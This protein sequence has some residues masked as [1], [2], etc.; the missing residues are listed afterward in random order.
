MQRKLLGIAGIITYTILLCLSILFY[1]ER[2]AFT[3]GAFHLFCLLKD[4]D[5]AIQNYR[6]IALFTQSFPLVGAYLGGSLAQVSIAYSVSFV[7]LNII[8]FSLLFFGFK[9]N[10]L[11][12]AY[13][14]FC[15]I[16]SRHS[17]Y[18][19]LSEIGQGTAACFV[20]IAYI[21]HSLENKKQI[22]LQYSIAALLLVSCAFAH[23]LMVFLWLFLMLFL[24][25]EQWEYKKMYLGS[26][27][28][29]IIVYVIK[30]I[31]FKTPNDSS[32]MGGLW[33][34]IQSIDQFFSFPSNINYVHYFSQ[35]YYWVSLLLLAS[36]IYYAYHKKYML[37]GLVACSFIAYSLMINIS[38]KDGADQFY[39]ENRYL[40]LSM[41]VIFPFVWHLL[42]SVKHIYWRNRIVSILIAT[43]LI[44]I[45][46]DHH[47]YTARL[48]FNRQL[49]KQSTQKRIIPRG[50]FS[51]QALA[52]NW[53]TSYEIW[54]LSTI[55]TGNTHS[56][57]IEDSENEFEAA[58]HNKR[59]L[60][61][62]WGLFDYSSF[63]R[64]D[65]FVFRDSSTAYVRY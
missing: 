62:K 24:A 17:F 54:L 35:D 13:L 23:P 21:Q 11:A 3:D 53:G 20:Y 59:A 1:K 57:I 2:I 48:D 56:I 64:K 14:L 5:Y 29:F 34:G 30:S 10:K 36:L 49:I 32:S 44:A 63:A 18:W 52:L 9:N 28:L 37:L 7:L 60:Q 41:Y 40:F 61:M 26:I 8:T 43:S 65:Y 33:Q 46:K 4:L 15:T 39:I 12:L 55:E 58:L 19:C 50:R 45:Y 38:T 25:L 31:F 51:P 27:G 16:M 47:N 22:W 6:F 42:P